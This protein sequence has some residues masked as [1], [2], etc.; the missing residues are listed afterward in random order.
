MFN[1]QNGSLI[2]Q[3]I[4]D[5]LYLLIISERRIKMRMLIQVKIPHKEFNAYV[6]DGSV[7]K[8]IKRI[9]D[10]IKPEAIYFTEYN[11][12]RGLIIIADVAEPSVVPKIAEPW[13]LMFNADVEFHI[14]MSPDDLEK[15]GL[16]NLAKKWV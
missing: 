4:I 9:F 6:K 7:E 10:E 14:V 1:C 13:F 12:R 11:G 8:K 2:I 3:K 5:K 15:A 16:G